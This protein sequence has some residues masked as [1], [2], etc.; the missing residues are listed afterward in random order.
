[1]PTVSIVIPV[2]NASRFLER[3]LK[4]ILHQSFTD[5]ECLVIDDGSTDGSE[6]ICDRYGIIDHRFRVFH[7]RNGG[8]S[9]ARN[10]GIKYSTGKW[11]IFVDA[12]DVLYEDSLETLYSLSNDDIDCI[13]GGYITTDENGNILSSTKTIKETVG[14]E[15]LLLHF[16]YPFHEKFYGYLWNRLLR[17][18]IIKK[19]NITFRD[20]IYI[21][22][23]GLFGIQFICASKKNGVYYTKPIYK[24]T[25]NTNGAMRSIERAYDPK[26]LTDLDACIC[27][28]NTIK[29]S[30]C[31]SLKTLFYAR[32]YV[33]TMHD[34]VATYLY[35]FNEDNSLLLKQLR[36]KTI[37]CVSYPFYIM[38]LAKSRIK[39]IIR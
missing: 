27:I 26:Y 37:D 28:Y 19:N 12:D 32:M 31:K 33:C 22:E 3:C 4:S 21:K 39:R 14:W 23:D 5:W 7:K 16:Y 15:Q 11:I 34:N 8:V 38:M 9:S 13:I 36:K 2:Y 29:K 35:Q 10:L 17:L 20:D 1:M 18:E 25:I 6:K 24:Y 30:G